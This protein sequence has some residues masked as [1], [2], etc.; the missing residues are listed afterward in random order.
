MLVVMKK[1]VPKLPEQE[2]YDY[3]AL[4]IPDLQYIE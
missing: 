1:V 2:K 4:F 3:G